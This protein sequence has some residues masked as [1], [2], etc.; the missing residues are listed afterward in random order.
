MLNG[1]EY[2]GLCGWCDPSILVKE[3]QEDRMK[4]FLI[5]LVSPGVCRRRCLGDRT[6]DESAEVLRPE[7][8]IIAPVEGRLVIDRGGIGRS[9]QPGRS[10]V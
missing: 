9:V 3:E 2:D 8:G 10:I 1:T 7:T 5:G 4:K 6:T